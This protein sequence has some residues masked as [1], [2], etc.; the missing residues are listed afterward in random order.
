MSVKVEMG[1]HF[2]PTAAA[3]RQQERVSR[4]GDNE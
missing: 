1:I 4:Q 2:L 3:R